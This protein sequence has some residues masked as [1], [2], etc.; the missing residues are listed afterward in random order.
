MGGGY[1]RIAEEA[2]RLARLLPPFVV[3]VIAARLE[4]DDDTDWETL[5][6]GSLRPSPAPIT[7]PSSLLS[8][9]VGGRRPAAFSLNPLP[10]PCSRHHGPRR[11]IVKAVPSNWSGPDRMSASSRRGEPNRRSCR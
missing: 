3:E 11:S 4:R 6:A 7:E 5:R 10:S 1:H 2:S 8:P 9:I